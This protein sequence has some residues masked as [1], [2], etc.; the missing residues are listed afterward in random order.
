MRRGTSGCWSGRWLGCSPRVLSSL[1]RR[2]SIADK[3]EGA[4]RGPV[5]KSVVRALR[6]L[7]AIHRS[8]EG[9][10]LAEICR[11][12]GLHKTT[13]LRLLRTLVALG[14][15]SHDEDIGVYVADLTFWFSAT[16]DLRP[17]LTFISA[18]GPD[19]SLRGSNH[20]DHR[21]R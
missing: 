12:Q 16:P 2:V 17:P 6:V 15:V 14:M 5:L 7:R 11:E 4:P 19:C 3:K 10:G 21:A 18:A 20:G 8:P 9:K 13:A 1:V